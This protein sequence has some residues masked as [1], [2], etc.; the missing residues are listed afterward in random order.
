[1]NPLRF[2][3]SF[4][5]NLNFH[6]QSWVNNLEQIAAFTYVLVDSD[7]SEQHTIV[8]NGNVSNS[9]SHL[10]TFLNELSK[11]YKHVLFLCGDHESSINLNFIHFNDNIVLLNHET[12][13]IQGYTFSNRLE[14]S[15][16]ILVKNDIDTN[17]TLPKYVFTNK[18]E[19]FIKSNETSIYSNTLQTAQYKIESVL[20]FRK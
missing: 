15:P 8:I 12:V 19:K 11:H 3:I 7:P 1:M 13:N 20:L 4:I 9:P 14:D 16:D 6:E 17:S 10:K 2:P 5:S 18:K